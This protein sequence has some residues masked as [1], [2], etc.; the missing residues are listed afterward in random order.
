V[1]KKRFIIQVI[2]VL[3]MVL[4]GIMF[5]GNTVWLYWDVPS[6]ILT[7]ILP[8]IVAS[9]VIS[10]G[11]QREFFKEIFKKDGSP[12]RYKLKQAVIFFDMLKKLSIASAIV[13]SFIGFIGIM[14]YLS[15]M[16]DA[17]TIGRN[18]GVLAICPFYTA[19]FILTF[20]EPLK[21]AA[22]KNLIG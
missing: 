19:I 13:A 22:K 10:F 12:D 7:P 8:Y 16:T 3:F 21:G 2:I 18:I 17:I 1:S 9:F 11:E 15:E 4:W 20:I 6:L 5:G 14:G